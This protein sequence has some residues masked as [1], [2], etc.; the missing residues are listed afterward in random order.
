MKRW[1]KRVFFDLFVVW[2]K[3][4]LKRACK[5]AMKKNQIP[6]VPYGDSW[7]NLLIYNGGEPVDTADWLK[8]YGLNTIDAGIPSLKAET[9]LGI[10]LYETVIK[11]TTGPLVFLVSLGGNDVLQSPKRL[12]QDPD[13]EMFITMVRLRLLF[14]KIRDAMGDRSLYFYINGYDYVR[15]E[16]TFLFWEGGLSSRFKD[17]TDAEINDLLNH[18]V[19]R[20]NEE[21]LILARTEDDIEYID[22]RNT[23]GPGDHIEDFHP[24][25][26]GYRKLSEK[27]LDRLRLHPW[28]GRM[29]STR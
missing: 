29:E 3:W 16:A 17:M 19:D 27:I 25:P 5:A 21:L 6:V 9:E 12:Q 28:W 4:E 8:D 22:L 11:H 24:T 7:I 10:R 18:I 1:L 13:R 23:L 20:Y 26:E 14:Q 2:R 15:A